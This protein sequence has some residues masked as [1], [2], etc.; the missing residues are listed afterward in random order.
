[1]PQ[2]HGFTPNSSAVGFD[3]PHPVAPRSSPMTE[4]EAVVLL[5]EW[6]ERGYDQVAAALRER[7]GRTGETVDEATEAGLMVGG[8]WAEWRRGGPCV[9]IEEQRHGE[10]ELIASRES[11]VEAG[12][13]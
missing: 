8:T 7:M 3:P 9:V 4:R 12:D 2:R 5:A 6:F 1:M 11:V 10:A 13:C